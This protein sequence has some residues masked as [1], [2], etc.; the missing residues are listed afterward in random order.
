VTWEHPLNY[1]RVS[2]LIPSTQPSDVELF[3]SVMYED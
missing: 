3:G 1:T 2:Y